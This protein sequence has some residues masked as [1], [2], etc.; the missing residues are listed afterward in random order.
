MSDLVQRTEPAQGVIRGYTR[1]GV[2]HTVDFTRSFEPAGNLV[3]MTYPHAAVHRD[4][5][6]RASKVFSA[7][8]NTTNFLF[9]APGPLQ[10]HMEWVITGGGDIEVYFYEGPTV[11]GEGT[12]MTKARLYLPSTKTTQMVAKYGGTVSAKGT[13]KDEAYNGG[14]GTG[15]NVRG[16]SVVHDDAEWIPKLDTWYLIEVIRGTSAKMAVTIEWYEVPEL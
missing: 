4:T 5:I 8:A 2:S 11:T 16:G 12:D 14:G 9:K 13:L 15:S 7:A 10:P 3:Q 6:A 1:S